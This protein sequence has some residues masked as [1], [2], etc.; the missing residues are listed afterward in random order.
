MELWQLAASELQTSGG[1]LDLAIPKVRAEFL[2]T[3]HAYTHHQHDKTACARIDVDT[4]SK[5]L[6]V[7][8][9]RY[10]VGNQ[11][12]QPQPF[13]SMRLDWSRAFGGK[14]TMKILMA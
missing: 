6:A 13:E 5:S 14:G 12:T 8:G 3:G 7:F 2:A 1:V 10:W 4:L 9:D 11:I